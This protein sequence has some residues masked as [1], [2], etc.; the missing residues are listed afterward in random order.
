M[1]ALTMRQAGEHEREAANMLH[2]SASRSSNTEDSV[3]GSARATGPVN[4]LA[5]AQHQPS[6]GLQI[7]RLFAPEAVQ[8]GTQ[9]VTI[10]KCARGAH[11]YGQRRAIQLA[12]SG[13][14]ANA[15]WP[16]SGSLNLAHRRGARRNDT[17][18]IRIYFQIKPMQILARNNRIKTN[19]PTR[20]PLTS[21]CMFRFDEKLDQRLTIK[22]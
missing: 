2:S 14:H 1:L 8:N 5:G 11:L 10:G 18:L 15:D 9:N 13:A 12:T 16:T 6:S 21:D 19:T 4:A 17:D 7:V 22:W 3:I 20:A